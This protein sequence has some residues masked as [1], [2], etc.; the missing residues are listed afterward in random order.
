MEIGGPDRNTDPQPADRP[1]KTLL[2][3]EHK[4]LAVATLAV[5]GHGDQPGQKARTADLNAPLG[6]IMA[7]GG[8]YALVNAFLSQY[9]GASIGQDLEAP[10]RTLTKENKSALVTAHLTHFYGSGPGEGDLNKPL[11]TITA[12]GCHAGLVYAFLTK[13]FGT[14]IGQSVTEPANTVTTKDHFGLVVVH[15]GGTP[16]VI[17]DIG[18]RMLTPRE[19]ARAQGFEDD[20][21]IA[22]VYNG[23]PLTHK[24]Q[25]AAIGNSVPPQFATA[26]VSANLDALNAPTRRPK[27]RPAPLLNAAGVR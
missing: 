15:V 17:V 24:A 16:Y 2:T 18:L 19:L 11:K 13:Y 20:Y 9:Y 27:R 10:A 3:R 4:A 7:G 14:A 23:K 22:P 21:I 5:V 26:I 12:G 1:C 25:V 8:K 6:T